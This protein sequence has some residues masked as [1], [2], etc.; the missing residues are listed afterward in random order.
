MLALFPEVIIVNLEIGISLRP[1]EQNNASVCGSYLHL[2]VYCIDAP[3]IHLSSHNVDIEGVTHFKTVFRG[4]SL[5]SVSSDPVKTCQHISVIEG[6]FLT[7][8]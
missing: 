2:K 7:G 5:N 6:G 4:D 1:L 3:S 8:I